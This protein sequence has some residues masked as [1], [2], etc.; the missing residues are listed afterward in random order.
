MAWH[1][2][3]AVPA[4][5]CEELQGAGHVR[6]LGKPFQHRMELA[7]RKLTVPSIRRWQ[8]QAGHPIGKIIKNKMNQF[9]R[10]VVEDWMHIE[11]GGLGQAAG[12]GP[13]Q[14]LHGNSQISPFCKAE[15]GPT[16]GQRQ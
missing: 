16:L 12:R 1:E 6:H 14:V 4:N 15:L 2:W 11:H 10:E 9:V 8:M 3:S 5:P 13:G 7:R